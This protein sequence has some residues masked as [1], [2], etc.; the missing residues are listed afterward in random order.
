MK[1]FRLLPL[2]L[3]A[4]TLACET[5]AERARADS[6][7]ALAVRQRTLMIKL[8]AQKDSLSLVVD[9]ADKFITQ[10]DSQISRVKGL[11]TKKKKK[12]QQQLESPL[13]E[14][15]QARK[16]M[17]ARVNALVE[18]ARTTATQLA[19][20]QAREKALLEDN[21][22]LRER[23]DS[24]D[25][26]IIELTASIERQAATIA[27]L[28]ARAD[29]LD[30][31]LNEARAA[32]S[33]GYYIIGREDELLEKGVIVREG[34]ANLLIARVGRTVVPAR[35]LDRGVF[36]AI[37]TRQVH[38]IDVPDT[39][40]RYTIISRQSLDNAEVAERDKSSFRG[41]LKITNAPQFW[42]SSAYLIILER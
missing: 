13:E 16:E 14:Q 15:V 39:T 8:N 19:E 33:K 28:T 12:G 35:E 6:A 11:K 25:K 32:F 36:T 4:L 29:S 37:D 41:H 7:E 1:L 34:G 18:R 30:V 42:A 38:E 2:S 26:V 27:A 31:A 10:I 23:S 9:D 20:A 24:A 22:R 40:R 3:V 17:L 21:A 5:A